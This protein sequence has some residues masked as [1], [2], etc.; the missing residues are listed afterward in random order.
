[1][2]HGPRAKEPVPTVAP[3]PVA[4]GTGPGV[5]PGT[6]VDPG[7]G[8][9]PGGG[10][11][12]STNGE[13]A[14]DR[15]AAALLHT[16]TARILGPLRFTAEDLA[17]AAGITV[18]DI[19]PIWMELGF[20]PVDRER[21]LF[22]QSDLQALELLMAVRHHQLVSDDL[23]VALARVLG[24]A[25]ARVAAT[26]AQTLAPLV[27]MLAAGPTAPRPDVAAG[28]SG[29]PAPQD[30]GAGS[31]GE[32]V[33]AALTGGAPITSAEALVDTVADVLVPTIDQ[34]MA[35]TWRRHLLAAL[36]RHLQERT[37]EVVGVAPQGGVTRL[38][39]Q[40]GPEEL[41]DVVGRFQE[42]ATHH[43]VTHGGRVVKTIGDAVLFVFPDGPAAAVGALGLVGACAEDRGLPPVRVGLACGPVVELEGDVYGDTV[44]R[45]SR[46]VELARSGSVLA[47]D[48]TAVQC[49]DR[50][51]LQVRPLRPRRLKG[52]G[53]VKVWA[54][55]PQ[56]DSMLP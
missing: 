26:E 22:A 40:L 14:M 33:R 16:M 41:P 29:E 27:R 53:L 2:P 34:F 20:V 43:L 4:P 28:A 8:T 19:E 35:W 45:A 55:R 21:P 39:A 11:G 52:L 46:L 15:Q 1:M 30:A 32:P 12:A 3:A 23:A 47:D 9:D 13:A 48:D 5:D 50:D 56:R 24:Q 44:N 10:P 37:T 17:A 38:S 49:L 18:D 42:L 7:P 31:P 51:D 36:A 54:L 6:G 25:L